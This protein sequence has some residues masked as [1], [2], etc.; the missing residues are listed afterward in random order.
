VLSLRRLQVRQQHQL[1][2]TDACALFEHRAS[3][4]S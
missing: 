3:P 1:H 4:L 2:A